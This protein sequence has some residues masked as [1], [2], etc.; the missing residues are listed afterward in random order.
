VPPV[1]LIAGFF[2]SALFIWEIAMSINPTLFA[3]VQRSLQRR[4][5]LKSAFVGADAMA[6]GDQAAGGDPAAAGGDPAMAGG[7]PA[8]AGGGA[9]PPPAAGG[10]G[11]IMG[12]LMPM[13]QQAVQQAMATQ[14][15]G[16]AGAGAAG[17]LK[18]KIDINVEVMK[19][20]KMVARIADALGVQI[21]AAEMVATPEDLNQMAAASQ[22]GGMAAPPQGG[23]ALGQISP[24]EPMKAAAW[25]SGVAFSPPSGSYGS[26][27]SDRSS[28]ATRA[29]AM[30]IKARTRDGYV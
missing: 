7:D 12:A 18:P 15:G 4:G 20:N 25:E 5:Q 23:G 8:M 22:G 27:S 30:L 28:V 6:G 2:L 14:G 9:A 10:G 24:I 26:L 16:G 11:D 21:S 19:L 17:G 1:T 3:D 29:R 13:I